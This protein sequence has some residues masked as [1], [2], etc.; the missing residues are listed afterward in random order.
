MVFRAC[1]PLRCFFLLSV[2]LCS[3]LPS[4]AQR[5]ADVV[6]SQI[7]DYGATV[8]VMVRDETGGASSQIAL[9]EISSVE[10]GAFNRASTEA[11]QV[12][13]QG[14]MPGT[15]T[16][17]VS[18]PGYRDS[19]QTLDVAGGVAIV[20]VLLRPDGEAK[21]AAAQRPPG[22]PIL[23]PKARKLATEVVNS[24]KDNMLDN[25]HAALEKLQVLAPANPEVSYLHGLYAARTNDRDQA[26]VYWQKTLQLYPKHMGAL[27]QLSQASIKENKPDEALPFLNTALE[28]DPAGW[29]P[30]AMKAQVYI[31][32][33][34][35]PDAVREANRALEL[36]HSE[37]DGVQPVL[38]RALVYQGNRERAIQVLQNYLKEHSTDTGAQKMLDYLQAPAMGSPSTVPPPASPPPPAAPAPPARESP[39]AYFES[40]FGGHQA[41]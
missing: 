15:Y 27:L 23:S 41:G 6:Q 4:S 24:L 9:V 29:R 20:Q 10:G 3:A 14:I 36:G 37:A 32:Q 16:V 7:L 38:A 8:M 28:V 35:Y 26:K 12:Q 11:G 30:H 19:V 17:K 33:K 40:S 25:A 31:E 22:M 39:E 18:A 13:F 34:Q 2:I 1:K 21:S 5:K